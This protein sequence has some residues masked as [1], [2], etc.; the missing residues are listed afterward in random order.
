MKIFITKDNGYG[1][2]YKFKIDSVCVTITHQELMRRTSGGSYW[3]ESKL[4][5]HKQMFMPLK[6]AKELFSFL[7]QNLEV[8]NN[9]PLTEKTEGDNGIPPT[10]KLVGILPNEL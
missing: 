2:R 9:L 10:N 4:S 7:K 6:E 5:W 1:F 8:E 3:R